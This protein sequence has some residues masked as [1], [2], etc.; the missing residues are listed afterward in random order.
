M[1]R[2]LVVFLAA[3]LLLTLFACGE[4]KDAE[5]AG[6]DSSDIS[7]ASAEPTGT[8]TDTDTDTEPGAGS[9]T[10][11]EP[12]RPNV[13]DP[14]KHDTEQV[15]TVLGPDGSVIREERIP[16]TDHVLRY[17]SDEKGHSAV[18]ILCG[19]TGESAPHD[20]DANGVCSVCG[21]GCVHEF[22][23]SAVPAGCMSPGYTEHKCSICGY[24][25]ASDPVPAT[26]H[27][28]VQSVEKPATC[29]ENGTL[30]WECSVCGTYFTMK[31]AVPA[32]GHN[33]VNGFCTFC[34][35]PDPSVDT[36]E[37]IPQDTSDE[38]SGNTPAPVI[39]GGPYELPEVPIG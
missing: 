25:Y 14:A 27:K 20:P 22:A 21:Y 36:G 30:R 10:N 26:G 1:K 16:A 32:T 8:A 35:A 39:P 13:P 15:V 5:T 28:F 3:M 37:A 24:S 4:K 2:L 17:E 7:T 19:K 38:T 31:D 18:C 9:E 23:E 34:G 6:R 12:L 11:P 29:T 33:Y